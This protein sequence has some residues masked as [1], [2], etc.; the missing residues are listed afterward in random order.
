M[1]DH[2]LRPSVENDRDIRGD[3]FAPVIIQHRAGIAA[4]TPSRDIRVD[5]DTDLYLVARKVRWTAPAPLPGSENSVAA[6]SSTPQSAAVSGLLFVYLR[7]QDLTLEVEVRNLAKSTSTSATLAVTTYGWVSDESTL[8]YP[9]DTEPGDVL[10]L[11]AG[12]RATTDEDPGYYG[13]LI[14]MQP[15]CTGYTP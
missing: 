12:V 7:G 14:I 10:E 5:D 3:R 1:S 6:D 15:P 9:V 4:T 11:D 8:F 2:S 13:G